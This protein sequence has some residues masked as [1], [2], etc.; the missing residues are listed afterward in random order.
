MRTARFPVFLVLANLFWA[1]NFLFGSVV[2]EQLS[3]FLMTALRWAAAAPILI[4]LAVIVERPRWREALREWPMHLLLAGLG[5]VCFCIFSYEALRHTTP[6]DAS[7]VGAINPAIIAVVAGLLARER[8]GWRRSLGILVSLVGVLIVISGG[9]PASLLR[10]DVNEGHVW[11]LGAVVVW[12]GYTILGRRLTTG[13]VT[14][15]A[16]QA[17]L[18]TIV[19]APIA[20]PQLGDVSLDGAAISGLLYIA[21]F[22]SVL[23]LVLWNVSVKKVGA[24]TAGVYLN[25]LPVFTAILGLAIGVALGWPTVLGGLLVVLGVT[26]TS[27]SRRTPE[28]L[29]GGR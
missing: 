3:P 10:A 11:M 16:V 5:L 26:I 15:S 4:L 8:V 22:P 19:L 18:T 1:G 9:D 13:P 6:A 14:A 21:V 17:S 28:P 24:S 27:R 7:V 2:V 20:I 25:L 12:T 29:T 23:S